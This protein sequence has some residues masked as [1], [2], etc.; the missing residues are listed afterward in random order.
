AERNL[1]EYRQQIGRFEVDRIEAATA[2]LQV[3]IVL[4]KGAAYVAAGRPW[5]IGRWSSDVD[6]LVPAAQLRRVEQRLHAGGWR[7]IELDEYDERYYRDWS[8]EVP[9]MRHVVRGV[10][11]DLHHTIA[12]VTGRVRPDADALVADAVPIAGSRL[13]T[14]CPGDQFLNTTIHLVQDSDFWRQ[15]RDLVDLDGMIRAQ[16]SDAGF[17]DHL[18]ARAR[19]HGLQR[20][21]FYAMHLASHLLQSP[22]PDQA[23]AEARRA[24]PSRPIVALMDALVARSMLPGN[25]DA[26]PSLAARQARRV[27]KARY[28]W[29]RFPPALFVRHLSYKAWRRVWEGR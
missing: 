21:F 1:A 8:H 17:W 5:A 26:L 28:M 16:G 2:G 29:L 27:L 6:I 15:L 25:L 3:P 7:S 19:L 22:I 9:P 13:R 4:L 18:L 12:R 14:L 10:E 11:V 24:A 23:M 20:P